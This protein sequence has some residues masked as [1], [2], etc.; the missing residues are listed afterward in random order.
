MV[1]CLVQPIY[2]GGNAGARFHSAGYRF[3]PPPPSRAEVVVED[4]GC[5]SGPAPVDME[6]KRPG[7][8][9]VTLPSDSE[10]TY[11]GARLVTLALGQQFAGEDHGLIIHGFCR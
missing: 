9:V 6:G 10:P 7:H 8:V 4:H 3:T 2:I 11:G 5:W 1:A